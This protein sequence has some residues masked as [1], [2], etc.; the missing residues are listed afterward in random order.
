MDNAQPVMVIG[1]GIAGITAA[2]E[3][4]EAGLSVILVE[5]SPFLGGRVARFNHYF[6]KLCPPACGLEINF[7]RIKNNSRITVL[8]QAQVEQITGTPGNF[9]ATVR[10]EPRYVSAVCTACGDCAKACPTGAAKIAGPSP[11]PA[12]YAIDRAAC[13]ADC[14][15]C[16]DACKYGAVNLEQAEERRSYKVA[17]V[18][19]ATGWAPYDARKIGNLGYGKFANV[20]TNVELEELAAAGKLARPSDGAT[21]KTVA[22]AQCAGSRD[23]NHLP[24]CSA[25]CC[26][27]SLKHATYIRAAYPEAKISIFYIDIR[28][29]GRL[30]GFYNKVAADPLLEL[31]KGKAA[32]VEEDPATKEILV[33]A[34]DVAAGKMTTR[35]VDLLVLATGMAP[36]TEAL[37][38]NFPRDEFG[39]LKAAPGLIPAGCVRRPAEVSATRAGCHGGGVESHGGGKE[40]MLMAAPLG[41]YI[42]SGCGIGDAIDT[43]KLAKCVEAGGQGAFFPVRGRRPGNDSRG[44]RGQGGHSAPVRR[45]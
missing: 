23:E 27:A 9:E 32:K 12:L 4:A 16:A 18:V 31:I 22:F 25:A 20:V 36:A 24:Y 43:D 11:F 30:E 33:T 42:C 14:H 13:K 15:A 29:T 34:E 8:T 45:A 2:V 5:K 19:A 41:V 37:P 40:G 7:K 17:A 26:A 39:F 28:T 6:P 10:L 35:K 38:A 3:A 21:L 1:G 44:R